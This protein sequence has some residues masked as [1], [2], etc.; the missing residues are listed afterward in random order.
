MQDLNGCSYL[1]SPIKISIRINNLDKISIENDNVTVSGP[2]FI[3]SVNGGTTLTNHGT[4]ILTI[5]GNL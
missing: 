2:L 1:N 5:Q 3:G 4:A